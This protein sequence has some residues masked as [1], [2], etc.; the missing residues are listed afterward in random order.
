M[1]RRIQ[2]TCGVLVRLAT[3]AVIAALAGACS[4][5]ARQDATTIASFEADD[6]LVALAETLGD[7]DAGAAEILASETVEENTDIV[8]A[9]REAI[10]TGGGVVAALVRAL[11]TPAVTARIVAGPRRDVTAR[12]TAGGVSLGVRRVD[13]NVV[14]YAEWR[15]TGVVRRLHAGHLRCRLGEQLL[16]GRGFGVYPT[17]YSATPA[18]RMTWSPA[19]SLAG[20][21]DAAAMELGAGRWRFR[22]MVVRPA[23]GSDTGW[24]ESGYES[25]AMRL[26]IAVGSSIERG[27]PTVGSVHALQRVGDVV[28]SAEMVG[29]GG[30][31]FGSARLS[32]DALGAVSIFNA[33][34]LTSTVEPLSDLAPPRGVLRGAVVEWRALTRARVA[35]RILLTSRALAGEHRWRRQI[36]L[37][38][39]RRRRGTWSIEAS[40]YHSSL[41]TETPPREEAAWQTVREQEGRTRFRLAFDVHDKHGRHRLRLD[42]LPGGGDSMLAGVGSR[43]VLGMLEVEWRFAAYALRRGQQGFIARP[44]PGPF[45]LFGSVYG[46]GSDVAVRLR[47]RLFHGLR[48]FAYYG[49]PYLKSPRVYVGAEINTQKPR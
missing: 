33:P 39:R 34:W 28:V 47:A 25:N 49:G 31:I 11:H 2:V 13:D 35:G 37:S 9:R 14:G 26:G 38:S 29:T 40:M 1:R 3:G 10:A 23:Q 18:G 5:G 46:R 12:A 22:S 17:A 16:V 42:Y 44:G 48:V 43:M 20:G 36:W 15:G 6:S 8:G 21:A 7:A 4:A 30:A 45:E 27:T 41:I 19:L 24:I 32:A